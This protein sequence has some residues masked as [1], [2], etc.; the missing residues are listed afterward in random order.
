MVRKRKSNN[1]AT[2][3]KL[4][5]R[6]KSTMRRR[7]KRNTK[8]GKRKTMKRNIGRGKYDLDDLLPLTKKG[9]KRRGEEIEDKSRKIL[10]S[11][12][13]ERANRRKMVE[14][15]K[16]LTALGELPRK[17][18]SM[19]KSR[20]KV[21]HVGAPKRNKTNKKHYIHPRFFKNSTDALQWR[22]EHLLNAPDDRQIQMGIDNQQ[23]ALQTR[24]ASARFLQQMYRT[25]LT[26]KALKRRRKAD[27]VGPLT[28][29]KAGPSV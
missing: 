28:P 25:R 11:I 10:A 3:R 7:K 14:L 4:K 17:K 27:R 19:S 2:K 20:K 18:N 12:W 21:S 22:L 13:K 16:R 23:R 1:Y 6:K 5:R 15:Q 9:R 8:K 29:P 26:E 24:D